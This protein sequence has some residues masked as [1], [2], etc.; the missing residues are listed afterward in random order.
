[1]VNKKGFVDNI[2]LVITVVVS[3]FVILVGSYA[4]G[5][6]KNG[7]NTFDMVANNTDAQDVLADVEQSNTNMDWLML[8]FFFGSVGAILLTL[9]FLRSNPLFFI[10]ALIGLIVTVFLAIILV[11]A[12]GDILDTNANIEAETL[13]YPKSNFLFENLPVIV[14]I[15]VSI[16]LIFA[17]VNK[18]GLGQ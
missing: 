1:M 11:D 9:Y 2:F 8:L 14:L 13:E 17:Y 7:L 3:F 10:I 12:F 4:Y 15:I 18:G 6:V 16:F 5:Q